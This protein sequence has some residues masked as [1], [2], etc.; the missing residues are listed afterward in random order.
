MHR[1][2]DV[3]GV[4][5]TGHQADIAVFDD[6]TTVVQWLGDMPST[7]VRASFEDAKKIHG[8][9]GK[10]RFVEYDVA[11][12]D[13]LVI[14]EMCLTPSCQNYEVEHVRTHK[15]RDLV[16]FVGPSSCVCGG[17]L[18]IVRRAVRFAQV[19]IYEAD[20]SWRYQAPTPELEDDDDDEI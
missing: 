5:G 16:T 7:T 15:Y 4:S 13:E 3:T 18:Y 14:T 12:R 1:D 9:D 6:G 20:L 17:E 2:V 11:T 19:T 8:H 10:T